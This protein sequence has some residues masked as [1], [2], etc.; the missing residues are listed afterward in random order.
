MKVQEQ[1]QYPNINL[2]YSTLHHKY[3]EKKKILKSIDPGAY[4]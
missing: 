4:M 1:R 3:V 2:F